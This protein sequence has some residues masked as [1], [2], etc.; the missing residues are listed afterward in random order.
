MRIGS[1]KRLCKI[2]VQRQSEYN[3]PSGS[4]DKCVVH[5]T[6]ILVSLFSLADRV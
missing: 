3:P 1:K 5:P 2:C 4:K 6:N